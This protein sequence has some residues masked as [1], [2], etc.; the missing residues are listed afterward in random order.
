MIQREIGDRLALMVLEGKVTD[1]ATV[2]VDIDSDG[3]VT[4]T[5]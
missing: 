1:G 2:T 5:V 3:A 4:L